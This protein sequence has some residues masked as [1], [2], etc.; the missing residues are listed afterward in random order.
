MTKKKKPNKVIKFPVQ[1]KIEH[2]D[3]IGQGVS[4]AEQIT[5]I[6]KV[7][8]GE[9]GIA[10]V[11]KSKKNIQFAK[12]TELTKKSDQRT[13]SDCPHYDECGG[14]HFLHTSYENELSFKKQSYLDNFQR[15]YKIDLSD[16]LQIHAAKDRYHYR[17][18]I[19]LHYDKNSHAL[20][21]HNEDNSRITPIES[22]LMANDAVN[23]ELSTLHSSWKKEAKK[24]K[25]HVEIFQRDGKILKTYDSYYSAQ[26]F[27]QVNPPMNH[28]L[29]SLLEEKMLAW[30]SDESTTVDLFGGNGNIT[31]ALQHRTLVLDATP[32]KYI[33]LQNPNYQEYFELDIYHKSAID[34]LK[35]FAIKDIDLLVID[36][37]RSGI[38]NIDE[39]VSLLNPKYIIYVSC[40]NQT[41]ARDTSK[42]LEDYEILEAHLFDFFPST[43]HY[44][45]VNFFKHR[46]AL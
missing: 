46:K 13:T 15:Q 6:Q 14:C 33:K 27:L 2:L 44:E 31:K 36:P 23:E 22:C 11:F 29:L 42:I 25:G 19:Q 26:G 12:M 5:F 24:K 1:F 4:K 17:N 41:L 28:K 9:E 20:G 16:L 7:L 35:K 21:F 18:R 34:R 3:S 38:K 8:P 32:E 37:P 30:T 10:E 39:F 45:S 43:R 40:N